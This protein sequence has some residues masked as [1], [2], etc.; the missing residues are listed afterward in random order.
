MTSSGTKPTLLQAARGL[1]RVTG[2]VQGVGFRPFVYRLASQHHL[3]GFVLNDTTG[4][5]IEAQGPP[6]ALDSFACDL[7]NQQPALAVIDRVVRTALPPSHR[8]PS[9]CTASS[10]SMTR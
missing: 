3:T 1:W 2:Q 5:V 4:V 10:L 9:R 6:E 8:P 7:V